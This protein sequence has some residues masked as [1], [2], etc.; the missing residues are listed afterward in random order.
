[1]CI[2]DR[3]SRFFRFLFS[4]NEIF[5]AFCDTIIELLCL[6]IIETPLIF[7]ITFMALDKSEIS[8]R[9]NFY[10]YNSV[11]IFLLIINLP[12]L[13]IATSVHSLSTSVKE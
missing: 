9:K 12:S 10:L 7:L 5:F 8:I 4:V 6:E 2:R 11:C 13:K 3:Y 1:M